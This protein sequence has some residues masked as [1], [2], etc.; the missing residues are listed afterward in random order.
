MCVSKSAMTRRVKYSR[1]GRLRSTQPCYFATSTILCTILSSCVLVVAPRVEPRT[2]SRVTGSVLPMSALNLTNA[3]L[4]DVPGGDWRGCRARDLAE[5]CRCIG[6]SAEGGCFSA[7]RYCSAD[8][9]GPSLAD[10]YVSK[11]QPGSLNIV[12]SHLR[13]QM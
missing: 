1:L 7:L 13:H 4:F 12:P 6:D 5:G 9:V 2:L 3:N 11:C 10:R 8:R